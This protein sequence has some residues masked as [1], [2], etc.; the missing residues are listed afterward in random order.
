MIHDIDIDIDMAGTVCAHVRFNS[1][2]KNIM[3]PIA[4]P[5]PL[6]YSSNSCKIIYVDF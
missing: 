3:K 1:L 4:L 2:C 6:E 5:V